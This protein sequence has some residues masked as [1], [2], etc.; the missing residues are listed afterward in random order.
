MINTEG[1]KEFLRDTYNE[2]ALD[3]GVDRKFLEGSLSIFTG[4]QEAI[5]AVAFASYLDEDEQ[6]AFLPLAQITPESA[7]SKSM[8]EVRERIRDWTRYHI[9]LRVYLIGYDA[10]LMPAP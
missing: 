4:E 3:L 6:A 8:F 1:I 5:Q 7:E 9:Y 10:K 2:G